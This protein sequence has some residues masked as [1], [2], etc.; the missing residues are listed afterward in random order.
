MLSDRDRHFDFL[1]SI[2]IV[3][4]DYADVLLMQNWQH[5]D[6]VMGVVNSLPVQTRSTTDYSRVRE[7]ALDGL[8]VSASPRRALR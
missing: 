7:W 2:E 3:M 8:Y 1:S 4:I 5:V 6:T